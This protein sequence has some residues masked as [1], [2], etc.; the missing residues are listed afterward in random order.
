MHIIYK[1]CTLFINHAHYLY[2]MLVICISCSLF[3]YHARYLYIMLV[4]Y[5]SCSLFIYHEREIILTQTAPHRKQTKI[6][7][8]CTLCWYLGTFFSIVRTCWYLGTFFWMYTLLV[9]WFP[10]RTLCW[11][12]GTFFL[13]VQFVGILVTF[14]GCTLCWYPDTFKFLVVH[15]IGILVP[16]SSWLYTLL[17]S[18]Y[19]VPSSSWL[20]TLLVSCNWHLFPSCTLCWYLGTFSWL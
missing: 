6:P 7:T 13:V 18:W 1:P 3:I 15:F 10:G 20:Y 4:I 17:V 11:Y 9:P 19:M 14:P 5:I 16:S 2:I 8:T 12:P